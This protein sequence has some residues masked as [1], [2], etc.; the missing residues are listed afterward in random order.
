M[1]GMRMSMRKIREVL[2]L[3][4]EL[5]LSVRE[6]R[7]ATGVG[8]TA[9][10]EYVNRAK[11][12]GI[13]WP[14]PAEISDA[15]LERLLF[16]PAGFHEGSPKSLPDWA[17][18]HEELK[19]RGVTL[20]ILW[21]EY[22]AAN[23]DG[24]GYSRFC[25]LYGEW[26][27]RLAP[28]MRQTHVAGDK[29]FVDWAGDTVPIIDAMTGEVHEAHLFVAVLGASSYTYA[30]ARWSETLP[31]WIGA[32]VNALDFIGG[33]PKAAVPDNLKAGITKPSRYE[34]GVNRTYQD[35]ADHYGFVVL[36][37]RIRRPRD[38]A[39]VEA[40]VGIVSRFVRGK[41]R[42]RRFFSLSELNDAVR[43]CVTEINAKVMKPLKRSRNELFVTLDWPA[44]RELPRE[45]YQYAEWKRCTVAPD[46][47]VEVDD[48]YYSVPFTLL[49][50]TVD[51]RFT[52]STVEV[53]HKGKRIASHLRSRLAHK[54]T[55]I[56]EHMP[57][58]HRRYAE[59]SPA[60]LLREA[61]KIGPA[62]VALFAAIMK[63]K[64]HPEQGF[65]SCLGI[66]S[67]MKSY[68]AE[69]IE[70]AATRG[71]DIGATTYGPIKSI[72]QNGLDRPFNQNTPDPSPIRHANIRG[73]S[74]YH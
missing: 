52:E 5:G 28:T 15:E 14:I 54:H 32:H 35:L 45:R 41:L 70:A 72:L 29:L 4:H 27:K 46:S 40:A 2:R 50:E 31:D 65:R 21:E 3:T 62:T 13:T 74:Y 37:A 38:K 26:R 48:H 42:D 67:L 8:K 16:T 9:V 1:A 53:F 71:N 69:R 60:R 12:I 30:E 36:P 57:S 18:V 61:E 49:R 25:A 58:S 55:T 10:G 17:K 43:E 68:G 33:V 51:T 39:K 73:R 20:M 11:V 64:P 47:H 63:A 34:P 22:R 6:V 19:R 24:H 66:L 56:P 44:L 59:W 23:V 7:A